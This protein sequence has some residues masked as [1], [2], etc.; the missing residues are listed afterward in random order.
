MAKQLTS[1]IYVEHGERDALQ[2][3]IVGTKGVIRCHRSKM[4]NA[5]DKRKRMKRQTRQR[6]TK[7]N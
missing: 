7:E 2:G 4:H 1:W 3:K 5:V 6:T